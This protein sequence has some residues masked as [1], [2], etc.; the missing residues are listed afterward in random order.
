[1]SSS[2]PHPLTIIWRSLP[3]ELDV[4]VAGVID[5]GCVKQ[6]IDSIGLPRAQNDILVCGAGSRAHLQCS[7][8]LAT[9]GQHSETSRGTG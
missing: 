4:E 2:T 7:I 9:Q 1:M 5:H 6:V 3:F 8:V